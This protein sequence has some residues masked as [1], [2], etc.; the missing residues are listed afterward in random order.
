MN[1]LRDEGGEGPVGEMGLELIRHTPGTPSMPEMKRRVWAALQASSH[2]R[3]A[4]P[5]RFG[6]RA[7]AAAAVVLGLCGTAGAVIARRWIETKLTPAPA[8]VP[9]PIATR[10][11][12]A[13]HPVA[14][15][16]GLA[17]RPEAEPTPAPARAPALKVHPV[18][19]APQRAADLPAAT[20]AERT[21]VL[22]AMIALR[23]DHDA[24]RAGQLL[25]HY[26]AAHPHGALREE[27]LVLAIEA[28][29]ARGDAAS[30]RRWAADYSDAY[31]NGRFHKFARE[32][33]AADAP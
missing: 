19:A 21:Q 9:A 5:R 16:I 17:P 18:K 26:L 32:T 1:R 15:T 10:V 33:L 6:L 29:T 2:E 8:T 23:R 24:A 25:D 14:R 22:D 28:A 12:P 3:A 7:F 27:A 30:A 20:A 13:P 31:P 4:A 11:E